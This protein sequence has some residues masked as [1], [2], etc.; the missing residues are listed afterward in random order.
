MRPEPKQCLR[1]VHARVTSGSFVLSIA[2]PSETEEPA[3]EKGGVAWW[4][5]GPD[6]AGTQDVCQ[7]E[8]QSSAGSLSSET[9]PARGSFSTMARAKSLRTS[10]VPGASAI[11]QLVS[12]F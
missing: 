2:C 12:V 10:A 1:G 6:V 7:T 8:S 11:T 5:R 9:M 3:F 4:V